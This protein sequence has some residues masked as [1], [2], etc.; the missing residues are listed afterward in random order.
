MKCIF[1]NKGVLEQREKVDTIPSS[2]MPAPRCSDK[3][4]H[5]NKDCYMHDALKCNKV[6]VQQFQNYDYSMCRGHDGYKLHSCGRYSTETS[7]AQ[8]HISE[9]LFTVAIC[10]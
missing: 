4:R 3:C 10:A 2:Q 6:S 1:Q 7:T 8:H 9:I 5:T